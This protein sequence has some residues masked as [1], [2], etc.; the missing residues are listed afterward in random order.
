M[1][2]R[3]SKNNSANNNLKRFP[4]NPT[5]LLPIEDDSS[6]SNG[7]NSNPLKPT[8]DKKEGKKKNKFV[9]DF[10]SIYK[11]R[12]FAIGTTRCIFCVHFYY[13]VYYRMIAVD[14][15]RRWRAK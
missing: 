13:L 2:I 11:L 12:P 6:S 7:S 4:Y 1:G 10:T 3:P 15:V 9:R 5:Q 14:S 8:I